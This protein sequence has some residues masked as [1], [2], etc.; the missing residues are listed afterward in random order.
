MTTRW[1]KTLAPLAVVGA[2][3]CVG[4]GPATT[5]VAPSKAQSKEAYDKAMLSQEKALMGDKSA[6]KLAKPQGGA[7]KGEQ[8]AGKP[9]QGKPPEAPK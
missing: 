9:E 8:P 7:P 1:L 5:T 6:V 4:C 3:T 2:L